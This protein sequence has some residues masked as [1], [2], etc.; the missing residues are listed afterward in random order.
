MSRS[1]ILLISALA[2][3]TAAPAALAG[4]YPL[5]G[6][7]D[8]AGGQVTLTDGP[9]GVIVR[10]EAHGLKP[11]WHAAHFHEKADCSDAMFKSAGGHVH[12][13]MPAIHGL[14]NPA[15][16]DFGDLP[17]LFAGPDGTATAEFFSPFVALQAGT[18]RAN[19]LDTD[20][21]AIVIH[22]NPDDYTTQPIGGA[23]ER[24]ACAEIR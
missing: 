10:V 22:A 8:G 17:N 20:G 12:M 16:N 14:L 23:G 21:S 13:M 7:A 19:L 4:T 6:A 5:R 3:M 11:G 1:S 9:R 15:G 24:V 2:L 18:A